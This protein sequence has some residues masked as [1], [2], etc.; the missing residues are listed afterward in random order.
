VEVRRVLLLFAIVLGLAAIAG[1]VANP[2]DDG[3]QATT[4]PEGQPPEPAAEPSPPA[5]DAGGDALEEGAV[6]FSAAG[7]PRTREVEQGQPATVLVE[8]ESPGEVS[9]PS[10]GLIETAEPLTPARFD[11]FATEP[12]AH[13]IVFQPARPGAERST[14]GTLEIVRAR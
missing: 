11:V 6:R 13:E 5:P 1:S 10:L 12:A 4:A 7:S 3:E 14:I 8:V 2:P 9:I